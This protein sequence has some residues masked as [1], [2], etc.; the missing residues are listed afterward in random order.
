MFVVAVGARVRTGV[1]RRIVVSVTRKRVVL[2]VWRRH[3]Q[4]RRARHISRKRASNGIGRSCL[5]RQHN[6][7][8][9]V[10]VLL[11]SSICVGGTCLCWRNRA[12]IDRDR[13]CCWTRLCVHSLAPSRLN[14]WHLCEWSG[15]RSSVCPP[16]RSERDTSRPSGSQLLLLV[17]KELFPGT[18][19]CLIDRREL[20]RLHS[21]G[22]LQAVLVPHAALEYEC[23]LLAVEPLGVGSQ[24]HPDANVVEHHTGRTH[25]TK[26]LRR[27][28]AKQRQLENVR[29]TTLK[30]NTKPV[31]HST[32]RLGKLSQRLQLAPHLRVH[33]FND[34]MPDTK[35]SILSVFSYS[36]P[37]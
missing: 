16:R 11:V 23:V 18:K 2:P 7:S 9:Q 24:L 35:D 32:I 13:W 22:Q 25:W 19:A 34:E 8:L 21:H 37:L 12:W 5:Q 36:H 31:E 26:A 30:N 29:R 3:W 1:G 14:L 4:L 15:R 20:E 28:H 27:P 17:L 10:L 6:C 33:E